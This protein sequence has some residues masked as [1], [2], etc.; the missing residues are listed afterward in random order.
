MPKQVLLIHM[1]K[2][3]MVGTIAK[4]FADGGYEVTESEPT[5]DEIRLHK[6]E[7]NLL[8]LYL[9][10]GGFIGALSGRLCGDNV[11]GFGLFE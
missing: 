6:D 8:V 3:F 9:Y 4:N 1:G 11:R 10:A 2:S 7:A 5:I